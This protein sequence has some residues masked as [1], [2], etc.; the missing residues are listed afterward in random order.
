MLFFGANA[1]I[2]CLF[3]VRSF[4]LRFIHK[5]SVSNAFLIVPAAFTFKF[6]KPLSLN[7]CTKRSFT[8]P[9]TFAERL[10][11]AFG[12]LL[13]GTVFFKFGAN[14]SMSLKPILFWGRLASIATFPKLFNRSSTD[15]YC[16][17][18]L[19]C[20]KV[21]GVFRVRSSRK[22][23][24]SAYLNLVDNSSNTKPLFSI[25]ATSFT[26]PETFVPTSCTFESLPFNF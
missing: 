5:L 26:S 19:R 6:P 3:A 11:T 25:K 2:N 24:V 21:C 4:I 23:S 7:S 1:V 20:K 17:F 10:S 22:V 9:F 8:I 12:Y 14:Q 18:K 15:L 13:N 16:N